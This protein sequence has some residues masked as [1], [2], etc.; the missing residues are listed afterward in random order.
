MCLVKHFVFRYD[1]AAGDGVA[2]ACCAKTVQ[3]FDDRNRNLIF[4]FI[5]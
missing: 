2:N 3:R 5:L 4:N 1:G